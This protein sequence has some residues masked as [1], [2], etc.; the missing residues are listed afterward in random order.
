MVIEIERPY[1]FKF[2][3]PTIK[4][5]TDLSIHKLMEDSSTSHLKSMDHLPI[6]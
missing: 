4:Q 6:L 1:L 5:M 2:D 3:W